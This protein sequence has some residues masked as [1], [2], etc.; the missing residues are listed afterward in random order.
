MVEY[1]YWRESTSGGKSR[2][3]TVVLFLPDVWSTLTARS[4]WPEVSE[5]Y[6]S[7]CDAAI[8]RLEDPQP[9]KL[10][11]VPAGAE[12]TPGGGGDGDA[13]ISQIVCSQLSIALLDG[14]LR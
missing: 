11:T 13:D 2:L 5:T 3:E 14:L 8:R 1:H 9:A 4:L 6:K 10:T 12:T 7:A